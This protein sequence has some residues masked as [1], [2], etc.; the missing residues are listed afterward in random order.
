M[1]VDTIAR[2]QTRFGTIP[3]YEIVD[4]AS[5]GM[6]ITENFEPKCVKQACYELR[7]GEIYYDL[8]K[9]A[10]RT[11]V[12]AGSYILIKP[13]QLIA[14]IT[15]EVLEIPQDVLARI[16]TKGKLFSIGLL[17]V[18]TYADPGFV[19]NLGIV[20]SNASTNYLKIYPGEPIAK[21][22]FS[23]LEH[24]VRRAYH[25]QHG[26]QT[27]IWPIPTDM[28]LILRTKFG[29]TREFWMW[30]ANWNCRTGRRFRAS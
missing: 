2:P 21:I 30:T 6:L 24:P 17:P 20:F 29:T 22:E 13:R 19:G 14:I 27:K 3:D 18:N 16:L 11:V 9:E 7:A 28:I 23:R 12:P 10:E 1:P 15:K 4:L 25:G 8:S 26:Y 5:R